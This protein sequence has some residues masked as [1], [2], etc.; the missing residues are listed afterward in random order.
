MNEQEILNLTNGPVRT[1]P[2]LFDESQDSYRMVGEVTMKMK[3][4]Q[5]RR[6]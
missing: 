4:V 2:G 1:D 5:G 6:P 3:R